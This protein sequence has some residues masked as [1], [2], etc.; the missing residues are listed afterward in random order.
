M[1]KSIQLLFL[2]NLICISQIFAL[3]NRKEIVGE[4]SLWTLQQG[5]LLRQRENNAEQDLIFTCR[6]PHKTS[7]KLSIKSDK[8]LFSKEFKSVENE[9][10]YQFFLPAVQKEQKVTVQVKTGTREEIRTL[11]MRPVK[12]LEL[13]LV[14]HTH[15]DLGYTQPQVELVDLHMEFIDQAI[16]YAEQTINRPDEEQFRWTCET[17]WAVQNYLENRP[18]EQIQ[19][20]IDMVKLGNI[21]VTAIYLNQT[22]AYNYE[23]M[24]RMISDA[25]QMKQK[26]DIPLTTAM[27]TDVN[28]IAWGYVPLLSSI[29]ITNLNMGINWTKGG[30]P[31]REKCPN[32]FFWKAPDGSELLVWNGDGY[33]TGNEL[34]IIP[35][36]EI[37]PK[38]ISKKY[39]ELI[40]KGFP[41]DFVSVQIQ[42][43]G[44]DNRPPNIGIC[45]AVKEWN[46]TYKSP[47]MRTATLNDY[48]TRLRKDTSGLP[49]VEG[50]W[51]DW[52][53]DG[54][55]TFAIETGLARRAQ[56]LLCAA[57]ALAATSPDPGV[58]AEKINRY[59]KENIIFNEHTQGGHNSIDEPW[60]PYHKMIWN[61]KAG[62]VYRAWHG[63]LKLGQNLLEQYSTGKEYEILVFNPFSDTFKGPVPVAVYRRGRSILNRGYRIHDETGKILPAEWSPGSDWAHLILD[64]EI[65]PLGF[66]RLFVTP[67]EERIKLQSECVVTENSVASPFYRISWD[68]EGITS[69]YDVQVGKE[70]LD[71]DS[72][73]RF[74]NIVH[75]KLPNPA[76]GRSGRMALENYRDNPVF[77]RKSMTIDSVKVLEPGDR[78][79]MV[80]LYGHLPDFQQ[81]FTDI[82]LYDLYP[83][84]DITLTLEKFMTY[85][86]ESIYLPM[87]F[88]M[89][90]P[91]IYLDLPGFVGEPWKKQLPGTCQDFYAVQDWVTV[92]DKAYNIVVSS[93]EA[94]LFQFDKIRTGDWNRSGKPQTGTVFGWP[95]NTYWYTNSAAY[96][97]PHQQF[98]YYITSYRGQFDVRKSI[99]FARHTVQRPVAFYYRQ[100]EKGN[101]DFPESPF[102][103]VSPEHLIIDSISPAMNSNGVMIRVR[104][105]AGHKVNG[106]FTLN[107]IKGPIYKANV[108]GK[109]LSQLSHEGQY[110]KLDINANKIVT[111][112]YSK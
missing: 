31:F 86:P 73:Y 6:F 18:K 110:Y 36:N 25:V 45:D 77:L 111:L 54:I 91:D 108:D 23:E 58:F 57:G 30:P 76:G 2:I 53:T 41:H 34:G 46:A 7:V 22:P 87:P 5:I 64:L 47:K 82:R 42:G 97:E 79:R 60:A 56:D 88:D 66:R 33:Q 24:A 16:E 100:P 11:I 105:L 107:G 28:G 19:K 81:L 15:T 75:E 70:L 32:G 74:G 84:V 20:F 48:F 99:E 51:P 62:H 94:P 26:Y 68:K 104:N 55:S 21:E 106:R 44:G 90:R 39:A 17:M 67:G 12:P 10:D 112:Y 40:G 96:Q 101:P 103:S 27:N 8:Q 50:D 59:Y 71:I 63:A 102:V 35:I 98:H 37:T 52:W 61:W 95:M 43:I 78:N 65:P 89:T 13:Y 38:S 109:P 29:G 85:D 14:M 92:S 83:R 49:R 1:F 4:D 3:G 80:R 72:S 69:L 9:Q 93:E